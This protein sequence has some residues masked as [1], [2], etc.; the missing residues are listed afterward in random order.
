MLEFPVP[1]RRGETLHGRVMRIDH[2]GNLITN[3]KKRDLEE[4]LGP[5]KSVIKAGKLV[6]EGLRKSYSEVETGETLAL[7]GSTGCLEIS[8]N[9]GRASDVAGKGPDALIGTEVEL[10]RV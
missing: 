7:I 5:K 2:F 4:F 6:I 3:V 9:K 10:R 8:V 1:E